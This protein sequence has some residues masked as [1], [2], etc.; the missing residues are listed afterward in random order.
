MFG[1]IYQPAI[2]HTA[3]AGRTRPHLLQC[4]TCTLYDDGSRTV[5][6]EPVRTWPKPQGWTSWDAQLLTLKMWSGMSAREAIE[7]LPERN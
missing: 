3:L 4:R 1:L 2:T 5:Y 7:E 6:W